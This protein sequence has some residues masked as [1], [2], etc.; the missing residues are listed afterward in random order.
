MTC[1]ILA[2]MSSILQH[3]L[4]DYLSA[5]DMILSVKEMFGEQM[6]HARQTTMRALMNSKIAEETLVGEHVLKLFDHLNTLDI[7][8]GEIYVESQINIILDSFNQFKLNYNMNK[9]NFTL[10]ELLNT[11][12]SAKDIIKGHLSVNSIEKAHI[13]N[14][15]PKENGK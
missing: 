2:S 15:F 9:I 13:P 5:M 11:L 1:S 10:T 4:K 7:L 12:Q 14:L 3:Q 6:R 8:G